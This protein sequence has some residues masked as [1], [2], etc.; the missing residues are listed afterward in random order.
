M[1]II[2]AIDLKDK[3]CVRLIQGEIEK[4]TIYSENPIE[5]AHYFKDKGAKRLHIVDLN[6]AFSGEMTN[7][8]IIRDIRKSTD[9]LIDVGGG[10]R[11]LNRVET[12]IGEGIDRVILGTIAVTNFEITSRIVEKFGDKISV[13]LDAKNKKIAIKGWV[14]K[15]DILALDIMKKLEN[16]GVKEFIYTDI[17]KDGMLCG[18]NLCDTKEICK[19]T[20]QNV[21]ISGGISNINDVK[22]LLELKQKNLGGVI[23]GKAIYAKSL[24]LKEAIKLTKTFCVGS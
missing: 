11:D 10:V 24:D 18:A 13:G 23:I 14:E 2:P 9:I 15:T 3:K 4:E 16:V 20:A 1:Q 22:N 5:V 6:G 19:K 21:I 17:S 12:L 8:E 7:F